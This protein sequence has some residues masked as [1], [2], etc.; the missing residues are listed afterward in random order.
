MVA[1][2]GRDGGTTTRLSDFS[3]PFPLPL[4]GEVR[5]SPKQ[6]ARPRQPIATS[7]KFARCAYSPRVLEL[8]LSPIVDDVQRQHCWKRGSRDGQRLGLYDYG[9]TERSF[10]AV[11]RRGST[12]NLNSLHGSWLRGTANL[13]DV[14]ISGEHWIVKRRWSCILSTPLF[15]RGL[16]DAGKRG[17]LTWN[18]AVKHQKHLPKPQTA[19]VATVQWPK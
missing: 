9:R 19:T 18:P 12:L 4:K 5:R 14:L 6:S 1:E 13:Y 17:D 2:T 7:G 11:E 15:E 3:M 8:M 16:G 10:N